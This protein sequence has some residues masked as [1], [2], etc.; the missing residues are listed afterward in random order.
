MALSEVGS[1]RVS[2][3]GTSVSLT[4]PAGTT[5]DD[6]IVI[7][8]GSD[9]DISSIGSGYTDVTG[10]P[11]DDGYVFIY[12]R[13]VWKLAGASEGN[14]SI[15]IASSG[16]IRATCYVLRGQSTTS[17]LQASASVVDTSFAATT[18][19]SS[20]GAGGNT[21]WSL[22]LQADEG[23][24]GSISWPTGWAL[25]IDQADTADYTTAI[26]RNTS[27]GTGTVS[28][29]VTTTDQGKD[30]VTYHVLVKEGGGASGQPATK[31]AGGIPWMGA[32]G[33]GFSSA[34]RRWIVRTPPAFATNLLRRATDGQY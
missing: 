34:A 17:P 29:G 5:T 20:L 2:A 16:R 26:A 11:A 15:G 3:T 10:S 4:L 13:C 33:A 21:V 32:H 28:P 30:N 1:A 23:S 27:P 18:T 22:I 24:R 6:L 8:V 19:P 9:Q 31:R 25:V 7:L 14:P 12:S